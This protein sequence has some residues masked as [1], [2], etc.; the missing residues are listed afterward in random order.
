MVVLDGMGKTISSC[1]PRELLNKGLKLLNQANASEALNLF[2]VV[3]KSQPGLAGLNYVRAK[4]L[5]ELGRFDE[6]REASQA[7]LALQ[8]GHK[9]AQDLLKSVQRQNSPCTS[10]ELSTN[11][12]ASRIGLFDEEPSEV[13]KAKQLVKSYYQKRLNDVW[14]CADHPVWFDHEVDYHLWPKNLFWLERGVYG[15]MVMRPGCRVLDLCCGDGY[16]SDAWYSTI[17][18]SIDACDNDEGALRFASQKHAN[19]KINYHRVDILTEPFPR[20]EYDVITWFEAIEHFSEE[21]IVHLLRKIDEALQ[22]NGTLIGS[23]PLVQKR[24]AATNRQHDREFTSQEDLEAIL[25]K[26]FVNVQTWVAIYPQRTTCYFKA[27]K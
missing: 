20:P 13:I 22:E 2:D 11:L 21:Q 8:A 16:Y 4:A 17:A 5:L 19:P 18:G 24:G 12:G 3:Y 1:S 23:T 7:E 14:C 9:G 27:V 15:R 10:K 6:A 26:V 25:K